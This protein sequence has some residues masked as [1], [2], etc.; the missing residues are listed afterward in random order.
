MFRINRII[1]Y[2]TEEKNIKSLIREALK[3]GSFIDVIIQEINHFV[4][5]LLFMSDKFKTNSFQTPR[6]KK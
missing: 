1:N 3:I 6:K 2:K 4:Y 5:A